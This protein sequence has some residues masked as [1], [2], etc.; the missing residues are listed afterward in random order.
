MRSV[1]VHE[2][3]GGKYQVSFA[4]SGSTILTFFVN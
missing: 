1:P 4:T 3:N 2:Y